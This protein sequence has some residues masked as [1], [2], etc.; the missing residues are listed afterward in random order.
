M[1]VV[2][3]TNVIVAAFATRG[4]CAEIFEVCLLDRIIV[5]SDFILSEVKEKLSNKIHLPHG[6]VHEII[7]YLKGQAEIV[8]PEEVKVSACKDKDD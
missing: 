6:I 2:L 3:D 4:L 5:L 7:D 1:K 8:N